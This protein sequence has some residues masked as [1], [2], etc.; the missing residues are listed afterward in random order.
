[1]C[2]K[3][4]FPRFTLLYV[5]VIASSFCNAQSQPVI[6][7]LL[8]K[9]NTTSDNKKVPLLIEVS[10][11]YVPIDASKA[12][13]FINEAYARSLKNGDSANMVRAG[14]IQS[15]LWRRKESLDDAMERLT[16]LLPVAERNNFR[17]DRKKI[18]NTLAII[19]TEKAKYDLALDYNFKSL[20]LREEDDDRAGMSISYNNIGLNYYRLLNYELALN[21]YNK[22]L[23]Y[24]LASGEE[25]DMDRLYINMGLCNLNLGQ[26]KAAK[27]SFTKGLKVCKN[28]CIPS[29]AI[30]AEI[31]LGA[32]SY[33]LG[34]LRQA[35]IH[36]QRSLKESEIVKDKKNQIVS[37]LSLTRIAFDLEDYEQSKKYLNEAYQIAT[38]TSYKKSLIHIYNQYAIHADHDKEFEKASNFRKMYI[39]LRDSIYSDEMI[40]NLATAQTNF[41]ERENL[42]TIESNKRVIE[43]Q[44]SLNFAIGF[45][46]ML[47]GGIAFLFYRQRRQMRKVN[48]GLNLRI[49]EATEDLFTSH[50]KL[51]KAVDDRDH[52]MYKTSHDIKG[53]L[54]TFIGLCSIAKLEVKDLVALDF[55]NKIERSAVK[56][57]SVL[58]RLLI[59]ERINHQEIQY[60]FVDFQSILDAVINLEKRNPA[61]QRITFSCDIE[62]G[63]IVKSDREIISI[64]LENL[65]SNSVKFSNQLSSS[66]VKVVIRSNDDMVVIQV[67]D[68]GI[69]IAPEVS[70][71]IFKLF[72]RGSERSETG[73]VGLYMVKQATERL[74]GKLGFTSTKDL[75]TFEVTLPLDIGPILRSQQDLEMKLEQRRKKASKREN[76]NLSLIF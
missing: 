35:T 54:S 72:V 46:L 19:L 68:N 65:I 14:W 21:F 38:S 61:A 70:P 42:A 4:F 39:E 8:R 71:S 43:Q 18:L 31:G 56:L 36:F 30:E 34:E 52:F 15:E 62:P 74:E 25:Y 44:R 33:G 20:K 2:Y 59:I 11:N 13:D 73:G 24:K 63:I 49:V 69:G 50:E 26:L 16:Y 9:L 45:I 28:T 53:P 12:L 67:I 3:I 40:K 75:T 10:R 51:K 64:I 32:S 29:I 27:E 66:F 5:F 1:V 48:T 17:M 41:V 76:P 6:D 55:F 60:N 23:E 57:N 37:L 58:T 47:L 22:A 7:S